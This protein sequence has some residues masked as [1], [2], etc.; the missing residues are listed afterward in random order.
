MKRITI[1]QIKDMDIYDVYYM[2]SQDYEGIQELK[3]D[4]NHKE[5][6]EHVNYLINKYNM[7]ENDLIR[8]DLFDQES[9]LISMDKMTVKEYLETEV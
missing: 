5:A 1:D 2:D 3:E 9:N 8:L 7:G 6:Y 4:M